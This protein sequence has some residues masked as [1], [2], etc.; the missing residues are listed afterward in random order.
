[1]WAMIE[2]L[3]MRGWSVTRE[4]REGS[5]LYLQSPHCYSSKLGPTHH[6][7]SP[8]PRIKDEFFNMANIKSQKKRNRQ[9]EVLRLRNKSVMSDL[10]SSIRKLEEAAADGEPTDELFRVTQSKLDVAVSKG[11]VNKKTAARKKSRLN[12]RISN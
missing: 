5:A 2:K 12:A 9:N 11:I 10:K 3:R 7:L 8:S 6:G 4:W 1:M